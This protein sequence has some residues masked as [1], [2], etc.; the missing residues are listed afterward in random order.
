MRSGGIYI[1]VSRGERDKIE[2]DDKVGWLVGSLS[3]YL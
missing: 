1:V 3:E 2:N